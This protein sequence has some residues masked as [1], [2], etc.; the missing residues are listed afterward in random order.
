MGYPY[1][2]LRRFLCVAAAIATVS[3]AAIGATLQ[4][5]Q[6]ASVFSVIGGNSTAL[7]H[8]SGIGFRAAS[9][10]WGFSATGAGFLNGRITF[11]D[12]FLLPTNPGDS[13][14]FGASDI[15]NAFYHHGEQAL[16]GPPGTIAGGFIFSASTSQIASASGLVVNEGGGAYRLINPLIQTSIED[17]LFRLPGG[18]LT[19]DY[20]IEGITAGLNVKLVNGVPASEIALLIVNS[21]YDGQWR[22]TSVTSPIPVPAALP[23]FLSGL[24]GLGIVARRRR[25]T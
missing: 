24:L 4:P 8:P 14:A 22:L 11:N 7:A 25:M 17:T 1:I 23:L 20:R 2:R 10:S 9:G 19:G 3:V 21:Q 12:A 13:V 18:L 16:P 6:A 15:E 5:V